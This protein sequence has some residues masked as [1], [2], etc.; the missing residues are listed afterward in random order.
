MSVLYPVPQP[1]RPAAVKPRISNLMLPSLPPADLE[2][3]L[4]MAPLLPPQRFQ[5]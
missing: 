3:I 2:P 1:L 5:R 4:T